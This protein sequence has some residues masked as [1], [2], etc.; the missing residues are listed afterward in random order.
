MAKHGSILKLLDNS[1]VTNINYTIIT[2]VWQRI[3]GWLFRNFEGP[4]ASLWWI[5]SFPFNFKTRFLS[6]S[7]YCK[8]DYLIA[9]PEKLNI[10]SLKCKPGLVPR[11]WSWTCVR[12]LL[13]RPKVVRPRSGRPL[14]RRSHLRRPEIIPEITV[15]L[16][17]S[18]KSCDH[19]VDEQLNL[20]LQRKDLNCAWAA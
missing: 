5:I 16:L 19:T 4:S 13:A 9:I 7:I 12:I 1:S 15:S 20:M 10:E 3:V 14:R 18:V 8:L 17:V 11:I 2:K 6:S